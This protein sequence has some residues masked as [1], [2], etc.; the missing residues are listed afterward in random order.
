MPILKYG[1]KDFR[2]TVSQVVFELLILH[3]AKIVLA[4]QGFEISVLVK[5][6]KIEGITEIRD[7]SDSPTLLVFTNLVSPLQ[8]VQLLELST[9]KLSAP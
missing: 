5:E 7:E 1:L 3:E 6:K 2:R 8:K 4:Q 9:K